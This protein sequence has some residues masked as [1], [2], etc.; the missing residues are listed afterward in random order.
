LAH[1]GGSQQ[2]DITPAMEGKADGRYAA[3]ARQVRYFSLA[4]I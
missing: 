4:L 3:G 2:C 1:C